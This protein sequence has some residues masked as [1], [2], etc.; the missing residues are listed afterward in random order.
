ME[1]KD[2]IEYIEK[3]PANTNPNVLKTMLEG[4]GGDTPVQAPKNDVTFYDYDGSIV[5]SYSASDF[6]NLSALPANPTHQGLAAQGWNWT[7]ADAK[8]YVASYGMLDIGQTYITDDGKTRLYI[9]I[10]AKDRMQLPL[11]WSQTVSNGV[12]ID[13]GDGSAT[14]TFSGTGHLNTTHTYSAIGSYIITFTVVEDCELGLGGWYDEE[15]GVDFSIVGSAYPYSNFIRCV[16]IGSGVTSIGE[17]AFNYCS[18]LSSVT[19]PNSVTS[20]GEGAFGQCFGM[21][22]YDFTALTAVPTVNSTTFLNIPDDCKIVVPDSLYSSWISADNWSSL[23]SH[24]IKESEWH[25]K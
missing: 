7:L 16:E 22:Y 18:S 12:T 5:T 14:E 8:A 13:W 3:T 2:I 23:A 6:A 1:I 20:I 4:L 25:G 19:I 10:A 21:A 17:Y 11:Y 24:I 15:K 9:T